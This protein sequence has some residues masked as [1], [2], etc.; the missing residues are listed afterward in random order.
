MTSAERAAGLLR[1]LWGKIKPASL[2][3]L[4]AE[5][6]AALE[7]K[8]REIERLRAARKENT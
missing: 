8:Q 1:V 7:E 5:I 2:Q 4:E 3:E 6:I